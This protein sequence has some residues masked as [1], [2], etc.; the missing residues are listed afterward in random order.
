MLGSERLV[1]F[2]GSGGCGSL[3]CPRSSLG[4]CGQPGGMQAEQQGLHLSPVAPA[5]GWGWQGHSGADEV[6]PGGCR[7]RWPPRA[8]GRAPAGRS[9]QEHGAAGTRLI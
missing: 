7:H 3:P 4:A 1:R 6:E 5:T 8:T 2:Q 9:L